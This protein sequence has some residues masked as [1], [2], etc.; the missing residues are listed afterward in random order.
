VPAL[1][2]KRGKGRVINF[3]IYLLDNAHKTHVELSAKAL[4]EG[5]IYRGF[6]ACLLDWLV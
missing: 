3:S 5:K 6:L 1:P 4:E 2:N